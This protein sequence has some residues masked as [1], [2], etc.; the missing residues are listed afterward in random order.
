[1][2]L[3]Q[4]TFT[5]ARRPEFEN[6]GKMARGVL[7]SMRCKKKR[8]MHVTKV[9]PLIHVVNRTRYCLFHFCAQTRVGRI[10]NLPV[11][12]KPMLLVRTVPNFCTKSHARRNDAAAG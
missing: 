8:L 7:V 12:E 11:N 9:V 3:L 10:L 2:P 5:A 4:R 1:M 6:D